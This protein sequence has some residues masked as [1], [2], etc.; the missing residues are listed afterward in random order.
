MLTHTLPKLHFLPLVLNT[1]AD[2]THEIL[3][4]N[5]PRT[6]YFKARLKTSA[7]PPKR[8]QK[9][10]NEPLTG[11]IVVDSY[12]P[13]FAP[14]SATVGPW[15]LQPICNIPII[16]FTLSWIMR[17]E[18]QKVMLV[19]SEKN[20]PYM[21]KVERRWKPCFESLNLICC[22]N[23]M[24]V[25]DALRELDTRGL[26]TGD[27]LLVSN[28][29]TFT[30]STLQTQIAAY[31][32]RRNEN[33]NNVMTVIYSDLK[34][35]R[36]AVVGIEKST[37]KL[38]IYHKQ[39]DPTQLDIDKPHFLGDAVIRRDI[40]D[41]G[42]AI[43]S[44]NISAQFSDNFDFQH[45]DDVIREI[46]VN[47]E[48]LLQNIHV[49]ILPPSEAALSIIDYYS[50]LVISNL[51]MERW[52]YP[53][54]PDR[55]TSDDCCGFNSLPGNV[56]IAVD[57][58]DFGRLSP[59]G[60]VCKRAFN[61]TFG[62]KCDVHESAVISCSTVGRG[63][64][65]GADTTI[66]NCIIGENCV[67]GANCRLEDSVIGNGVRIPDQTQLP[68]HSIISAGVS[69]VAG[70]DVPPNCALCS[71]P[72]HEDFDETINCKSVKDIHV[73]T[74][75]NGGPFFTVNGRRADSGNG[76]LGD[77]NENDLGTESEGSEPVELDATAQFYEEVV[78]SM[79]RIQGFTFSNQ[80]MHNLILEINS[81]KLAYNISMEDVAKYVFSAFLGLPGNET[82]SGLKELCTKWVLL[83][84]NY[85]KPKKSQVQLLLAV[86]NP[87]CII[88]IIQGERV[89]AHVND[90]RICV[91]LTR[92]PWVTSMMHK[93]SGHRLIKKDR[94]KEKP[95]EF[96]PM[97]ARLTHFLY[98]D[99]DVL[100][101]EAILEWAGSLDEESE[102]RRIM[103]PI[104]EWLQQDSD[105]DESEGE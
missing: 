54:V 12:D 14:L 101:E 30:S 58:E 63:S 94:Y 48:I 62:T 77:E 34:T 99:L 76:S 92:L 84:T 1:T 27:F 28:P 36:N 65:I 24:S 98:N 66:V 105:E 59:V 5:Y 81:S 10:D 42:I 70:L 18:V 13:R 45:R 104:V 31:R 75:A 69:Y 95:K 33:K 25:G 82:W 83:F 29:A 86:E 38:K 55:M 22:K 68:K 43:C 41:S 2:L 67:I 102:L 57:E 79:E 85:Y 21:E 49:E 64:Q 23:A 20:A 39:E 17:T 44:L 26:L 88:E 90:G 7:M 74:L 16:D 89:R 8:E 52:F 91:V 51:L 32:E 11:V 87:G 4:K 80:Q 61:T 60:S 78:E 15:C 37:K 47:E 71:S 19:V 9:K 93:A 100:E 56:Y 3:T 35:P 53:L 96:G 73:W 40:V 6:H 103:K 50:L 72:P 97:V 46:L